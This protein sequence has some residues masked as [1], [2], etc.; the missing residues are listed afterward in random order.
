MSELLLDVLLSQKTV[1]LLEPLLFEG[2]I[3]RHILPSKQTNNPICL[4]LSE[5]LNN[6]ENVHSEKP[7]LLLLSN[8]I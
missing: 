6:Q 3:N 2:T 5:M 7:P 1:L 4:N 8:L